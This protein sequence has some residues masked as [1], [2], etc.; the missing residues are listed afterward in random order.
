MTNKIL[1]GLLVV[2]SVLSA[3]DKLEQQKIVQEEMVQMNK[4]MMTIQSGF[5][6]K[7]A[8]KIKDGGL[9]LIN[10][11]K[12]VKAPVRTGVYEES[13]DLHLTQTKSKSIINNTQKMIDSFE[14]GNK[15]K[16]L[17]HYTL[18]TKQCVSCHAKIRKW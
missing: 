18:V 3:G 11:I 1:I 8:Q 7:N 9:T 10:V 5:L 16:A 2:S 13:K 14:K 12:N 4:A 6:T 15:Y 17:D